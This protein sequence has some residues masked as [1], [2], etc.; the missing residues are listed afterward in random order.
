MLKCNSLTEARYYI[1]EFIY[2]FAF[3]LSE[4]NGIEIKQGRRYLKEELLAMPIV[5]KSL[6]ILY[7]KLFLSNDPSKIK[8]HIDILFNE[9]LLIIDEQKEKYREQM[10][11]SQAFDGWYE[12]MVQHYNKIYH[13]VEIGDI[14]TPLFASVEYSKEV[15]GIFKNIGYKK[16]FPD[17]VS[18][19]DPND[20]LRI[21]STAKEHQIQLEKA[22][23]ENNMQI[24]RFKSIG[25]LENYL[26]SL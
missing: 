12:E 2:W 10:P 18:A 4:I 23:N 20:L 16:Y 5:P 11:F 15:N 6:S 8:E 14:F 21:G 1:I 26:D 17:M 13:A 19:Y 25:E 24:K 7:D 9:L 3:I 22:L